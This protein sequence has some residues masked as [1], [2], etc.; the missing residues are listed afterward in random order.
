MKTRVGKLLEASVGKSGVSDA[1]V[2]FSKFGWFLTVDADLYKGLVE[3]QIGMGT[4]G[5]YNKNFDVPGHDNSSDKSVKELS[6]QIAKD[7]VPVV[8][9]FEEGILKVLQKHKVKV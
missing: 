5:S 8:S 3:L 9:A 6:Q 2:D 7:L 4:K 1:S